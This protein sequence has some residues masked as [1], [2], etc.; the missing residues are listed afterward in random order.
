MALEKNRK[1]DLAHGNAS[2]SSDRKRKSPWKAIAT[3]P[4]IVTDPRSKVSRWLDYDFHEALE[5][6]EITI[7]D[8]PDANPV[9]ECFVSDGRSPMAKSDK[10]LATDLCPVKVINE[11]TTD[12]CPIEVINELTTEVCQVEVI[13]ELRTD[14]CQVEVN[15]ELTTDVCQ[16]EVINELTTDICQVEV[17]NELPTGVCQ[18]EVLNELMTDVCQVEVINELATDVCQVFFFFHTSLL[19]IMI[20]K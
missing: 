10:T 3:L 1:E 12:V 11:L 8:I 18:V 20:T 7:L 13:N 19:C 14:V 2:G 16:V 5:P 4:T 9:Q 17:I 15:D 6:S